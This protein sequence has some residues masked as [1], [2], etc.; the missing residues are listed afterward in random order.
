MKIEYDTDADALYI[1]LREVPAASSIDIEEG[2]TVDVD[3][4]GH[5]VGLEILGASQRLSSSDLSKITLHRLP[6]EPASA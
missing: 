5:I 3:A 1:A 6:A 4:L 2:V